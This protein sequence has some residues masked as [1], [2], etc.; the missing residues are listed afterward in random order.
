M[1]I[2]KLVREL[3]AKLPGPFDRSSEVRSIGAAFLTEAA[4]DVSSGLGIGRERKRLEDPRTAIAESLRTL[5]AQ[6]GPIL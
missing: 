5:A 2:E 3:S 6:L 4:E 1:D